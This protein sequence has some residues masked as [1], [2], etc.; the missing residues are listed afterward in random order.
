MSTNF[1][2]SFM[3]PQERDMTEMT[4]STTPSDDTKANAVAAGAVDDIKAETL[5][6]QI[7]AAIRTVFDPEIPVNVYDLGLI[8]GLDIDDAGFVRIDMTL[9][10]PMCPV[11]EILPAQVQQVVQMIDGVADVE[12]ELVW[13]P[14]WRPDRL[15]DDVKL[16]LGLL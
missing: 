8:Y 11:A 4:Q 15:T 7:I 3:N 10:S 14:P 5:E 6:D 9:T 13:D 12:L 2:D 16:E 1:L